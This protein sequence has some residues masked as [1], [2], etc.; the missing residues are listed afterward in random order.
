MPFAGWEAADL[1]WRYS[2]GKVNAGING[3][4]TSERRDV[5][6]RRKMQEM[7]W[8]SGGDRITLSG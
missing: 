7:L 6:V 3:V 4:T 1:H 2:Y 5:R 8:K